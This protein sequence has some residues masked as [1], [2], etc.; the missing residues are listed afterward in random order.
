M[1]KH[2]SAT[3]LSSAITL[4]LFAVMD[5]LTAQKDELVLEQVQP[6]RIENTFENIQPPQPKGKDWSM[7]KP[8]PVAPPRVV[9]P[10]DRLP[11]SNPSRTSAHA[12]PR[13]PIMHILVRLDTTGTG[14]AIP[15]VAML[16]TY[17]HRALVRGLEGW[18]DVEIDI[19]AAGVVTTATVLGAEPPNVFNQSALRA[20]RKFRFRPK[21]VDGTAYPTRGLRYR[22][23]YTRS[24]E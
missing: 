11:S 8:V 9:T 2:M 23:R 16:P 5:H 21:M 14:A 20:V 17:P 18:V 6:V 7:E 1:I 22:I 13:A 4:C 12:I 10:V 15:L 3:L 24:D 19:D